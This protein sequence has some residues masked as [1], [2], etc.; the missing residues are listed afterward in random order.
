VIAGSSTLSVNVPP[1]DAG[2]NALITS[3]G[4]RA[5]AELIPAK[6]FTTASINKYPRD[7]AGQAIVLLNMVFL[8]QMY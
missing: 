1:V 6:V 7:L 3:I 8:L 5:E 4:G 2:T